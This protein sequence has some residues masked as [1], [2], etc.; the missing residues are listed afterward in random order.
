[1]F[2][3]NLLL[4]RGI[5]HATAAPNLFQ[6]PTPSQRDSPGAVDYCRRKVDLVREKLSELGAVM[7]SRQ[8]VRE[9][10][11]Q[12]LEEKLVQQQAQQAQ[13]QQQQQGG[14]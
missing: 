4:R 2:S 11:E 14:T 8:S 9:Q 7:R 3:G 13:Q 5:P 6:S 12:V 1:L 10:V